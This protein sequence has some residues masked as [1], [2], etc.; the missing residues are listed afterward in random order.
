VSL[1]PARADAKKEVTTNQVVSKSEEYI[2]G[3]KIWNTGI[4]ED[5]VPGLRLVRLLLL[6]LVADSPSFVQVKSEAKA[7]RL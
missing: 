1:R 5:P 3:I 6:W 7:C 2:G 4:Q